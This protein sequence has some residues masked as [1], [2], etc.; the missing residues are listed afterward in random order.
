MAVI[1]KSNRVDIRI[2]SKDK[3]I[4]ERAAEIN[5]LSLSSYI[6]SVCLKQAECDIRENEM[7]KVDA[8]GRDVIMRLLEEDEEPN[9]ALKELFK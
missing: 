6:L 7:I 4:L 1:T 8:A 5:H 9:D 2:D 3:E